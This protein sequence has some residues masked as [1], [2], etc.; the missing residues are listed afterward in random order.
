MTTLVSRS[1]H[2]SSYV[3]SLAATSVREAQC[4]EQR[5]GLIVAGELTINL[6]LRTVTVNNELTHLTKGQFDLLL[7]LLHRAGEVVT[8]EELH[9]V[10]CGVSRWRGDTRAI[11]QQLS[12]LAK[13]IG[14]SKALIRNIRG[15]GYALVLQ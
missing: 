4:L 2:N 1:S 8:F 9:Q 11:R 7:K 12:K 3:T 13:S 10:A 5:D 15:V 6:K 14:E